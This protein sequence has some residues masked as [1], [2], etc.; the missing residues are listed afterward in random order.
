MGLSVR[1]LGEEGG[2]VT[3]QPTASSQIY[4]YILHVYEDG[5]GAGCRLYSRVKGEWKFQLGQKRL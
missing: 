1:D 2:T 5:E 3:L 4:K